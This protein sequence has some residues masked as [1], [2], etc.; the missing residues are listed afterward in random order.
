MIRVQLAP[1]EEQQ[2]GTREQFQA[3]TRAGLVGPT[4]LVHDGAAW[5]LAA[6]H[7]DFAPADGSLP[8][9][10]ATPPA[11]S[12][13]P[14]PPAGMNTTNDLASE[15]APLPPA[16]D[17]SARPSAPPS[18]LAPAAPIELVPAVAFIDMTTA[19]ARQSDEPRVEAPPEEPA[20]AEPQLGPRSISDPTRA[21][22]RAR[23]RERLRRAAIGLG[24]AAAVAASGYLVYRGGPGLAARLG[25]GTRRVSAVSAAAPADDESIPVPAA[26]P[27]RDSANAPVA[28]VAERHPPAATLMGRYADTMDSLRAS[29]HDELRTVGFLG[30][31]HPDRLLGFQDLRASRRALAA[32]AN[33]FRNYRRD[34]RVTEQGYLDALTGFRPASSLG[35]PAALAWEARSLR[36]EPYEVTTIGDSV[37]QSMDSLLVF[38]QQHGGAYH[39]QGDELAFEEGRDS[40]R[41]HHLLDRLQTLLEAGLR[42]HPPSGAPSA[43][44]D[45]ARRAL[46]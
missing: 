23:A 2:F 3:A 25:H 6:Q 5:V 4:A 8:A 33:V 43:T 27:M 16:P 7:P 38:L 22:R 34:V 32:A 1:G 44:L 31:L 40:D 13:L 46:E 41:Y 39:I 21:L 26:L 28:A 45:E 42:I 15:M 29:M 11:M 18:A 14:A 17:T 20:H 24:A 30:M 35:G 19:P 12:S 10:P 36:T 37:T 9:S